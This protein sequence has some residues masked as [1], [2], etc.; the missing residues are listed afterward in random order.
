MQS[1]LHA[2]TYDAHHDRIGFTYQTKECEIR[3]CCE[4]ALR[5]VHRFA[6]RDDLFRKS[7]SRQNAQEK[8]E[9]CLNPLAATNPV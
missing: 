6:S 3:V 9:T 1:G 8:A 4:G 7:I 5:R 2:A